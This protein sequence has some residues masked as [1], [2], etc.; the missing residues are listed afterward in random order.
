MSFKAE[1][2]EG[3]NRMGCNQMRHFKF[4]KIDQLSLTGQF[5][6]ESSGQISRNF[7]PLPGEKKWEKVWDEVKYCSDK[8]RMNKN[9]I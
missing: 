5:E 9:K 3:Q 1:F 8:C 6:A 2:R 4:C 7:H